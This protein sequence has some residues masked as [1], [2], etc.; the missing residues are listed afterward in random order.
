[1]KLGSFTQQPQERESYTIDYADDLT[2]GDN[3]KQANASISP[4]GLML[5]GL[6]VLD[7]RL[8][9]WL[10]GGTAGVSYKISVTAETEDGRILLDH[11]FLKIKEF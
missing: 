6:F 3:L 11:F 7:P 10:R 5:D 9:L 4:D 8:R 1:M 2:E